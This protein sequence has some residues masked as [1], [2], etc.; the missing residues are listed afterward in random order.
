MPAS[1][2]LADNHRVYP[3]VYKTLSLLD[4]LLIPE[5]VL[6]VLKQKCQ[7]NALN[8]LRTTGEMVRILGPEQRISN[9]LHFLKDYMS[10]IFSSGHLLILPG[11]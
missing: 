5:Y 8:A 1:S 9:L 11:V 6:E 4:N 7:D 2:R 10:C 3:L